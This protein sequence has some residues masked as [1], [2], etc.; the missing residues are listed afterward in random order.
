MRKTAG[1]SGK[2]RCGVKAGA[3]HPAY[4]VCAQY[5]I[6][7]ESQLSHQQALCDVPPQLAVTHL[8][9]RRKVPELLVGDGLDGAGV[10]GARAVRRR[11]RKR[12]LRGHRLASRGVRRHKNRPALPGQI[13][14]RVMLER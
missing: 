9:L 13:G 14:K 11:Q 1:R 2:A 5:A 4:N 10:D 12:I 7:L 6:S 8:K 3:R